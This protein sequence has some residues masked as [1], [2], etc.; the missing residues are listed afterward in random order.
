MVIESRQLLPVVR[1]DVLPDGANWSDDGCEK[2][3]SCLSCPLEICKY[4]QPHSDRERRNRYIFDLRKRGSSINEICRQFKMSSRTVARIMQ[5][6]GEPPVTS[7][8]LGNDEP[9]ATEVQELE[10]HS[11]KMRDKNAPAFQS[12][13]PGRWIWFKACLQCGGD[14]TMNTLIREMSC[15]QCSFNQQKP[16]GVGVAT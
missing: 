3:P 4:D 12:K 10:T 16:I 11:F 2:S 14:V 7:P 13:A 8:Q 9:P 1:S 15:V 6:G 5:R